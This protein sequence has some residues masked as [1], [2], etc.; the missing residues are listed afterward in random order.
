MAISDPPRELV[1]QALLLIGRTHKAG[2]DAAQAARDE[3]ARWQQ[4]GTERA[5]AAEAAQRLWDGSDGSTLRD[6]VPLPRS[7]SEALQTRRRALGLL[8]AAGL[9]AIAA[10]G[11]RWY[12][13][14]PVHQ[15]ALETGHGQLLSRT[16]PDGTRLDLAARTAATVTYFRDR[17]EVRLGRG[18][19]RFQVSAAADRP[20]TVATDW[21]RVRVLGT[22][23]SVSA[24]E[25]R[26]RVAVAE[27]RV[28]VWAGEAQARAVLQAGEAVEADSRGLGERSA[29]Q[30]EEVG[31][32]RQ[33]W[34]VFDNTRLAEA[35]GRWND[36]LRQPLHLGAAPALRDLRLS[37]S[38]P[39]REPQ[40][41]LDGLPD[42]L[43]VRVVR[44]P[45]GA[46][47]IEAR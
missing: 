6:S 15:L 36:Y 1:E 34:L 31:A 39:L 46:A 37:G 32:W 13:Q 7:R 24:R 3:L 16:L 25:G 43:P 11:G 18:E 47:V 23:F 17:R 30:V 27:G 2:P 10:G 9:V 29:V 8:G 22:T 21:G 38:F 14:R 44:G 26:M 42:I 5:A 35:I 41:F 4:A 28:A 12:W 19:I 20:F 45:G 33:G 40:A